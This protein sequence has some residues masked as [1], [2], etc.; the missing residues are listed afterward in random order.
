[1]PAETL[2]IR[3]KLLTYKQ[4]AEVLGICPRSVA[5]LAAKGKLRTVRMVGS[6]RIDPA[7]LEAFIEASKQGGEA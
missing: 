7:D 3:P 2:A 5:S 6:V 4:A 1:M